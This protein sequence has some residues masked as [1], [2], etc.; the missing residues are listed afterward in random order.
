MTDQVISND[1]IRQNVTNV[2]LKSAANIR[3]L[4]EVSKGDEGT[5]AI[6]EMMKGM[7]TRNHSSLNF[8]GLSSTNIFLLEGVG[9]VEVTNVLFE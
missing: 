7:K 1:T 9:E 5:K 6:N 2:C 8:N 4:L 3:Q